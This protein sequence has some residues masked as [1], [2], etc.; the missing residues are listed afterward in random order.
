MN[1][2]VGSPAPEFTVPAM[3]GD[4]VD[5]EE[6][7]LSEYR[8]KWVVLF[9]YPLDFTFVCPTEVT[10]FEKEYDRF[11]ELNAEVIGASVDSIYAHM[12]WR[13]QKGGIGTLRFPLASDITKS[14][15]RSYGALLEDQGIALRATYIIDPD[16]VL[17]YQV[18]QDF[19]VGRSVKE[20][21]RVLEALQTFKNCPVDWQPGEATL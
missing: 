9:F 8:G 10:G 11:R 6:I 2:Q 4:S 18:V 16:G 12:A 15:S 5:P 19:G 7:S 21:L 13:E 14:L 20:T 1:V 17:R 3:I